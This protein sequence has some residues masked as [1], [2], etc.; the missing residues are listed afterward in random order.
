MSLSWKEALK[1]FND[2]RKA[3]GEGKY[4]IPKIGSPEHEQVCR[5]RQAAAET[6]PAAAER[7]KSR[8]PKKAR[9]RGTTHSH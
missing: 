3:K 9:K 2:E 4:M 1:Q 5:L 7:S 6:K 8:T